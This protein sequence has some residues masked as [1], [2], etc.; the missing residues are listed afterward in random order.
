[1]TLPSSSPNSTPP[2][3]RPPRID[4]LDARKIERNAAHD[5]LDARRFPNRL[6]LDPRRARRRAR[7]HRR[8]AHAPRPD[9]RARL[10]RRRRRGRLAHRGAP[11]SAR[12]RH[13]PYR[14][15]LGAL[16]VRADVLVTVRLD[17]S[18][19]TTEIV[20][21]AH[22][23]QRQRIRSRQPRA[24]ALGRARVRPRQD[25][26]L[27]EIREAPRP[28]RACRPSP[29]AVWNGPPLR[30]AGARSARARRIGTLGGYS[31]VCLLRGMPDGQLDT[32]ELEPHNAAVAQASST[33]PG[34]AD[35]VRIHVGPALEKLHEDR[36]DGPVDLG[37]SSTPTRPAIR[38][39]SPGPKST[40]AWA[41]SCCSIT[42]SAGVASSTR[43]RP[44]I[45][46]ASAFAD[47][48][49]PRQ[50]RALAPATCCR[51]RRSRLRRQSALTRR[52]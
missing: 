48:R 12:L 36:A 18:A 46:T 39:T 47:R 16:R 28:P 50:R 24:Q 17:F 6:P 34:V 42:R 4:R 44:S 41:A 19:Q 13:H 43:R 45:P 31:G 7:P 14:A 8:R 25:E 37:S 1:M 23:A 35:R 10:R 51:P 3:S 26:V 20:G 52:P 32:F 40:C 38:P 21:D 22:F 5:V 11:R 33:R 30:G 2:R 49:A 9:P 29:S 27:R 15:M